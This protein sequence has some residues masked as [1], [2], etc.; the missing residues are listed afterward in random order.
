MS[1]NPNRSH[2]PDGLISLSSLKSFIASST[3]KLLI[4]SSMRQPNPLLNFFPKYFLETQTLPQMRNEQ[5]GQIFIVDIT[6]PF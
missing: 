2:I 1:L 5:R 4:Y 3:L 6:L